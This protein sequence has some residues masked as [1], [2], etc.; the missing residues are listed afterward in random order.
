MGDLQWSE[1]LAISAERW[2]AQC[3]VA[4]NSASDRKLSQFQ[5]WV[6]QNMRFSTSDSS[7]VDSIAVWTEEKQNYQYGVGAVPANATVGHYTQIIWQ[8][9]THVG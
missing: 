8:N 7:W 9:T 2:A 4:H 6:G 1:E 3:Q 5:P